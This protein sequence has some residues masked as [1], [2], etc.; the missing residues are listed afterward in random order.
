MMVMV[1]DF[2]CSS[3]NLVPISCSNGSISTCLELL[4]S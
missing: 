3:L 4:P 2:S 1:S